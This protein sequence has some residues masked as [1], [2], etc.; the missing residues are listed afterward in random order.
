MNV[1]NNKHTRRNVNM[2]V[3][4]LEGGGRGEVIN[5]Y[6]GDHVNEVTTPLP[7]R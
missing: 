6:E 4:T 2:F 3:K 7:R 1:K 5:S